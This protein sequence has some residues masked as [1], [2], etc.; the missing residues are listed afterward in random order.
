MAP[1]GA[2]QRPLGPHNSR[3]VKAAP[4]SPIAA[5]PLEQFGR[6]LRPKPHQSAPP[7][8]PPTRH[9]MRHGR[10]PPR[11]RQARRPAKHVARGRGAERTVHP[12]SPAGA[13]RTIKRGEASPAHDRHNKICTPDLCPGATGGSS[14]TCFYRRSYG[15]A[16]HSQCGHVVL[17]AACPLLPGWRCD[18]PGPPM[19]QRMPLLVVEADPG[20]RRQ[21]V[22]DV[23]STSTSATPSES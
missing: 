6:A 14:S 12:Q 13:D 3:M 8:T 18:R 22:P 16:T 15:L 1:R 10:S 2:A 17:R 5:S 23:V 4:L 9:A 7:A 21:S 19:Q 11:A 20:H